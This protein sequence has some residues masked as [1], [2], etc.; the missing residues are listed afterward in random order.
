MAENKFWFARRFP[1]GHPRNAMAPV[2]PEGWI[3]VGSFAADLAAGAVVWLYLASIGMPMIGV[4]V[5]VAMAIGGA[6]LLLY[7]ANTKGD[8][9]HTVDDYKAGRV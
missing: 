5:F 6:G 7:M 3:L 8:R 9:S 2:S 4:V 1:V